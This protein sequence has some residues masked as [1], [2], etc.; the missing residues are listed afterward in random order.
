M[1]PRVSCWSA[2][3]WDLWG[4]GLALI[5]GAAGPASAFEAGYLNLDGIQGESS[6]DTVH[7]DWI[8]IV[9]YQQVVQSKTG[10]GF[11][12][13][14]T[15][16]DLADTWSQQIRLSGGVMGRPLFGDLALSKNLDRSS[17]AL[18]LACAQGHSIPQA[19]LE[20]V[21]TTPAGVLLARI[22]LENVQVTSVQGRGIAGGRWPV[23]ESLTLSFAD[24][25]FTSVEISATGQRFAHT[26][27]WNLEQGK[28]DFGSGP[29]QGTGG[30]GGE[31]QLVLARNL[32]VN[33]GAD[34]GVK[35]PDLLTVVP[36]QDW[37]PAGGLTALPYTTVGSEFNGATPGPIDRGAAFFAGGPDSA[38]S[39]GRQVIDVSA[40][41]T[42][43]D[44]HKVEAVLDGWLGGV[45]QEED[46]AELTAAFRRQDGTTLGA[47]GIGPVNSRDREATT[48]MIFAEESSRV[49]PGTRDI[50]VTLRITRF[51]GTYNDGAADS[52]RLI[53]VEGTGSP[54]KLPIRVVFSDSQDPQPV[55]KVRCSWPARFD[56]VVIESSTRLD[57]DWTVA[58][59]PIQIEGDERSFEVPVD[60]VQG[61]RLWRIR[62]RN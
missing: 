39:I 59:P 24:I 10:P 48:R 3:W 58:S 20:L 5:F 28:G 36:P 9:A 19:R 2:W 17:P 60:L 45:G 27:H 52:L 42:L 16:R 8:K 1:K 40:A 31:P 35:S 7:K 57:G 6:H 62:A 25:K 38:L 54:S 29:F 44:A 21:R 26:A 18:A 41:A 34:S 50:E 37:Q 53:L 43:I 30:G 51:S 22:E 14:A 12:S 49:P 23:S 4:T 15:L 61:F 13:N 56:Q 46:Q 47:L 32:L 55:R 11:M 33:P